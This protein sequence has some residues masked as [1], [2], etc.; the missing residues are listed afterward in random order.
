MGTGPDILPFDV[1]IINQTVSFY[2]QYTYQ[3][4]SACALFLILVLGLCISLFY[5]FRTKRLKDDLLK[6]EK[7]CGWLRT[8]QKNRTV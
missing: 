6:S 2:Q 7:T 3:I 8:V 4:W 5:Y 1:E